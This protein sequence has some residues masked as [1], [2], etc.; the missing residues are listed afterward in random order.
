M[1]ILQYTMFVVLLHHRSIDDEFITTNN[2]SMAI[3]A[4]NQSAI[5]KRDRRINSI[6]IQFIRR[7]VRFVIHDI[8]DRISSQNL[9][10]NVIVEINEVIDN[11]RR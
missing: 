8:C 1:N 7:T 5:V 3:Q 2:L 9:S 10:V 11:A 4:V 6:E